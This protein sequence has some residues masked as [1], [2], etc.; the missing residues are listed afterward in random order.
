MGAFTHVVVCAV[1]L[2]PGDGLL[3]L[4]EQIRTR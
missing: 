4:G 2:Q 1:Y 3:K